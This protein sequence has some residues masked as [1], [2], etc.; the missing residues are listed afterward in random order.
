[1]I[2]SLWTGRRGLY[3]RETT[4]LFLCPVC[5]EEKILLLPF[6]CGLHGVCEPCQFLGPEPV[7]ICPMCRSD[8]QADDFRYEDTL[9]PDRTSLQLR[10]EI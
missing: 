5:L 4:T 2:R 8:T 7:D 9:L 10:E 1:M 6:G 3:R